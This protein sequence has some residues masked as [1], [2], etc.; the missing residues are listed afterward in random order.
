LLNSLKI[1]VCVALAL[2][3]HTAARAEETPLAPAEIRVIDGEGRMLLSRDGAPLAVLQVRTAAEDDASSP[4]VLSYPDALKILAAKSEALVA[5]GEQLRELDFPL[6][7]G[8][9]KDKLGVLLRAR[10]V[11]AGARV[12]FTS[13]VN[14]PTL[15]AFQRGWKAP[16]MELAVQV[17]QD[18]DGKQADVLFVDGEKREPHFEKLDKRRARTWSIE[19][20]K[21]FRVTLARSGPTDWTVRGRDKD[22]LLTSR[23]QPDPRER[24]ACGAFVLY[25]GA[26]PDEAA[27]EIS[28]LKIERREVPA[29]DFVEGAVR[30]YSSGSNPF[31]LTETAVVA[32]IACPPKANGEFEI[33][34]LPCFFWEAPP[35]SPAEGEF[36]F[37]FAPPAEGIYGVR[38]AIVTATGQLRGDAESFRAGPPASNGFVKARENERFLRTDGGRMFVPLGSDLPVIAAPGGGPWG[39]RKFEDAEILREQFTAMARR[40]LNCARLMIA[41]EALPFEN[42][43]AG[44]YDPATAEVL[45][46]IFRAAQARD[47]RL[48]V[49]LEQARRINDESKTH[50]YFR[51]MNGPLAATP[52]FFRDVAAKRFFQNRLTYIAARYSAYRSVLAWDLMDSLDKSWPILSKDPE[53]KKLKFNEVDLCRR[54]RRDVQDWAGIMG[55]H[56]KGMDQHGHPVCLSLSGDIEKPWADLERVDT[57][58]WLMQ[59]HLQLD[60]ATQRDESVAIA[61]WAAALRQTGRARKPFTL[62]HVGLPESNDSPL[63][64]SAL[65]HNAMFAAIASGLAGSPFSPNDGEAARM[66]GATLAE[67]LDPLN[68]EELRYVDSESGANLRVL[69]RAGKRGAALWLRDTRIAWPSALSKL[70]AISISD[71]KVTLSG[72]DEGKYTAVWVE[73]RSGR[74]LNTQAVSASAKTDT[75]VAAPAFSGD[76]LLLVARQ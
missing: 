57:I 69:G 49:C 72:L 76:V 39:N 42:E 5:G 60:P 4:L 43:V 12:L 36:R 44:K 75:I 10:K 73:T 47:I 32:E 71:A 6:I 37:R 23:L 46:E 70:E 15:S 67:I 13:A 25:M 66:F 14:G 11:A 3:A 61:S 63:V 40:G 45:D 33:K 27:P 18:A 28:P 65:G 74:V 19:N 24:S 26:G 20:K 59:A 68:K 41:N 2:L 62:L 34:R 52:E 51:E 58:D 8:G 7:G 30:V 21:T 17:F 9:E 64:R 56:L 29:R 55:L 35:Q 54:A 22:V 31:A 1:F 16:P 48:I 38:I 53:D 50:P